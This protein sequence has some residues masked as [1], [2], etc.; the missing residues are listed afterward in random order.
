MKPRVQFTPALTAALICAAVWFIFWLLAF[1]PPPQ[2]P[3]VSSV[4]PSVTRFTA[5]SENARRLHLPE[6]FALPA[7]Q[8]FSGVFPETRIDLQ[9]AIE[10]TSNP[11]NFLP[12]E[13]A[14]APAIDIAALLAGTAL[15]PGD[16]PAPGAAVTAAPVLP[17]ERLQLFLSP[18]LQ[19]RAGEA[20]HLDAEP[21]TP[22]TVRVYLTVRADGAVE[23]ALFETPL[24]NTPLFSAVRKL[25]FKPAAWETG[26]WLDIRFVPEGKL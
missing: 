20:L 12:R 14:T 4:L 23:R 17:V 21:G 16:L 24:T 8:G 2:H 13:T 11:V 15:P 7:E 18:E 3:A 26:G 19:L 5:E 1:R 9:P 10:K 22:G 25:R 6:L